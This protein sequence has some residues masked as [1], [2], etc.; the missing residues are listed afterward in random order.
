MWKLKLDGAKTV[1]RLL[2][3]TKTCFFSLTVPLS[4]S[5]L[6]EIEEWWGRRVRLCFVLCVPFPLCDF[7]LSLC[8]RFEFCV[9]VLS[10]VILF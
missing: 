1:S 6:I 2:L 10:F 4:F 3:I 8:F 7:V 9:S 5:G